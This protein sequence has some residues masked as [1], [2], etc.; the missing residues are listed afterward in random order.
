MQALGLPTSERDRVMPRVCPEKG[1]IDVKVSDVSDD[2]VG[3]LQA[4][5]VAV[6]RLELCIISGAHDEVSEAK[7]R[8]N[9][10]RR[11]AL[12]GDRPAEDLQRRAGGVVGLEHSFDVSS[13]AELGARPMHFEVVARKAF[14]QFTEVLVAPHLPSGKEQVVRR[15]RSEEDAASHLIDAERETIFGSVGHLH[16][17]NVDEHGLP[18]RERTHAESQVAKLC[19]RPAHTKKILTIVVGPLARRADPHRTAGTTFSTS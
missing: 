11:S 10:V 12:R 2:L 3:P 17:K 5:E 1:Q 6:I 7:L 19:G 8:S 4:E 14:S 9:E 18:R 16:L 13:R 15:V